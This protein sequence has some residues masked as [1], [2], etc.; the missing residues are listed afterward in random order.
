MMEF[1]GAFILGIHERVERL[2]R[3]A[4][5]HDKSF[6]KIEKTSSSHFT[7]EKGQTVS[8]VRH[9]FICTCADKFA[10]QPFGRIASS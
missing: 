5:K 7:L 3:H 2:E 1:I 4:A 8:Y 6:E 10:R 9:I